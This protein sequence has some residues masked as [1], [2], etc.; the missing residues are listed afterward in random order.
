MLFYKCKINLFIYNTSKKKKKPI[1]C[2]LNGKGFDL[3]LL[4]VTWK[5]FLQSIKDK[6]I[7][8]VIYKLPNKK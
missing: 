2:N 6:P 7:H 1:D 4:Y 3:S 8:N 5:L